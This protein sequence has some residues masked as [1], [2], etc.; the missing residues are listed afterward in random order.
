MLRFP[1]HYRVQSVLGLNTF[2]VPF[3]TA[4]L[5]V[6]AS[7]DTDDNGIK[8]EHVSVSLKNRIPTWQELKFIKMLFWDPEDK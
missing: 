5:A 7:I 6:L 4:K 8:W 2:L 3:N 1:E